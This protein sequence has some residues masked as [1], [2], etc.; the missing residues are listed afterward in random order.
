ML[1]SVLARRR[2]ETIDAVV[3]NVHVAN[4]RMY[5]GHTKDTLKFRE[6]PLDLFA[7]KV[8][9]RK[10]SSQNVVSNSVELL[11]RHTFFCLKRALQHGADLVPVAD[12]DPHLRSV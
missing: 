3:T 1:V 9:A 4:S 2:D 12:P 10:R 7:G 6:V 11:R 5:V 8:F